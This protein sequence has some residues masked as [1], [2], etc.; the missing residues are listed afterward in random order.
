M[1][2]C[3]AV[4]TQTSNRI[5][6]N[7]IRRISNS[8]K[9]PFRVIEH[10]SVWYPVQYFSVLYIGTFGTIHNTCIHCCWMV[11][12]MHMEFSAPRY[13]C[14]PCIRGYICGGL[15]DVRHFHN[16][17]NRNQSNWL[18]WK[19]EEK[20]GQ[21]TLDQQFIFS[22]KQW[23]PESVVTQPYFPPPKCAHPSE[24]TRDKHKNVLGILRF[25]ECSTK[26]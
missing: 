22:S 24:G 11:A 3:V 26:E 4:F 23:Q 12:K 9:T 21:R 19:C 16:Q 17:S 25:S 7:R 10:S 8:T 2:A 13:I 20:V 6:S 15:V 5:E 18:F 14:L 1:R